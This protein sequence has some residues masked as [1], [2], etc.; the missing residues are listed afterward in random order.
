[1][2]P[3]ETLPTVEIKMKE[4]KLTKTVAEPKSVRK[5]LNEKS[6]MPSNW[7]IIPSGVNQVI[8]TNIETGEVIEGTVAEFNE[9]IRG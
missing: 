3:G 6:Y 8:A 5:L 9:I 4:I 1:M 7:N 2:R